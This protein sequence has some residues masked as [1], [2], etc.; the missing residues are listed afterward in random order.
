MTDQI[1][2]HLDVEAADRIMLRFGIEIRD[3]NLAEG[4]SVMSMPIAGMRNPFTGDSTVGTLAILVDAASGMV[5]H[6]GR[7]PDEWSVSSELVLE[8]SP[9][10]GAQATADVEHPVV[11]H[12][13]R[14]GPR[15]SSSLSLCT[16]KC[17]DITIGGGMVRSYFVPGDRVI[18]AHPTETL[19][20]TAQT[21]VSDLMAVEVAPAA[22][23]M[24]VLAQRIDPILNNGVGTVH[25]GVAAA[26]L[27]LA[28][29]AAINNTDGVRFRTASVRVNFLR[30]FFASEHSRYEATP[31]RIGRGT[32]VAD[33]ESIGEDGKVALIARITAYR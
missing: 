27:E 6:L 13:R 20:R 11:A 4:T 7:N 2:G 15:G 1:E 3:I 31:L 12:A 30:P 9:D 28:A 18:A 26:G 32:A 16:L 25:G 29:S 21:E 33:A 14:L 19:A 17:G 8:L 23:H 24:R 5:N 10:G 22:G